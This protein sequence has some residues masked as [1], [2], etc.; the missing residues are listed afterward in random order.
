MIVVK[1]AYATTPVEGVYIAI[2]QLRTTT[3]ASGYFRI[4]GVPPRIFG[5]EKCNLFIGYR[6]QAAL[7]GGLW[8]RVRRVV[9]QGRPE[10]MPRKG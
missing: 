3:D 10:S 4:D 8:R 5:R 9:I 6:E 1:S 2:E 7:Y